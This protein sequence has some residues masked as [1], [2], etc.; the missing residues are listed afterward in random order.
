M[1]WQLFLSTFVLIFVAELG[2]KTQLAAMARAASSSTRWTVFMAASLALVLSTLVAVL[3]GG[4]L[5]RVVP[6]RYIRLSAGGLFVVIGV[7]MVYQALADRPLERP[8]AGA[9]PGV[10]TRFIFRQA[11]AFEKA[12]MEDYRQ[13]AARSDDPRLR[14]LI[15]AILRDEQS[16]LE[17]I[18]AYA[19]DHKQGLAH[20]QVLERLPA[21]DALMAD[22]GTA[23][24]P[25]IQ[26]AI[27]HEA[28]TAK[29]YRELAG[30]TLIPSLKRAFMD[31]A[32]EEDTHQRKLQAMLDPDGS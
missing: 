4:A 20:H 15:E 8:A 28:A 24:R 21:H 11:A 30:L 5:T 23:S 12:A 2:D 13:M 27:E 1:K 29:F 6:E 22:A 14:T 25:M 31:L 17:R 26:H 18:L 16:H 7:M 9:G 32:A 19:S 3:V 10:V